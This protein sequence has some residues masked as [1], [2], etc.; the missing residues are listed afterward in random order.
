MG[1][2]VRLVLQVLTEVH[3][4]SPLNVSVAQEKVSFT[5]LT[6]IHIAAFATIMEGTLRLAL[7]AC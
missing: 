2:S 1:K 6:Q 4:A 3:L 5:T 7:F